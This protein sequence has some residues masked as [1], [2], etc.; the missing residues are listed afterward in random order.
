MRPRPE[1]EVLFLDFDGVLCDSLEECYRASWLTA[2]GGILGAALPPEPPTD[3]AYRARFRAC[4]PFIRSGEDYLIVHDWTAQGRVPADQ[5]EFDA[6]LAARGPAALAD[7]KTRLYAVR[8]ALL[9]HHKALWLGWNPL[10]EG[11]ATALSALKDDPDAWILSTKKAEFIVEILGHHGVDW[12]LRRT[13]YTGPRR[14]LDLIA[15]LAPGRPSVLIDDQID[16]LDFDHALVDCRLALWGYIG[17]G[18][19]EAAPRKVTL[20]EALALMSGFRARRRAG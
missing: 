9:E 2:Q 7:M 11:V 17:P 13:I 6:S 4:R 12:P 15:E 3:P 1:P 8:E 10:F 18:A 19:A 16:H 20:A 5:A 14:K